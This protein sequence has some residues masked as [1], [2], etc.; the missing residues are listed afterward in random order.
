MEKVKQTTRSNIGPLEGGVFCRLAYFY[1][2]FIENTNQKPKNWAFKNWYLCFC[3]FLLEA[4]VSED[5]FCKA[6][7]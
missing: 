1:D 3:F 4:L 2:E 5:L 6:Q 7:S